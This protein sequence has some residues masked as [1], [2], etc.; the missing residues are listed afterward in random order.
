MAL[1]TTA[2]GPA[3]VLGD[4]SQLGRVV[5]N[6]LENAARHA[7][8]SVTIELSEGSHGTATLVVADDGPGVP[9]ADRERVFEPFT[10]LDEARTTSSGGVG[11]G[12]AIVHD[13]VEAHE[14]TV[15]I[16]DRVG[17]GAAFVVTLPTAP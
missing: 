10:R 6:L 1:D 8:S 9:A 12:L 5:S 13:I 3:Q 7:T 17:G 15:S 14:G 16:A 4:P 2:V 11:L